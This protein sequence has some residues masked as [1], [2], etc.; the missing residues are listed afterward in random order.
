MT[1]QNKLLRKIV[2]LTGVD[3]Y[4]PFYLVLLN[5]PVEKKEC[6]CAKMLSD[7]LTF[8]GSGEVHVENDC[9][10]GFEL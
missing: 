5:R 7:A 6:D 4:D 3:L 9:L 10:A 1:F 2:A 8:V